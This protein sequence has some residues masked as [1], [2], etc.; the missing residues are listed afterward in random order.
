MS[1]MH[2]L[3]VSIVGVVGV[4]TMCAAAV[5]LTGCGDGRPSRAAVSGNVF[6]DGK[7]VACGTIML[8]PA[9]A[10]PSS[11]TIDRQGRFS[12]TCYQGQD[13]AVLGRHAL[14]VA[15]VEESDSKTIRWLAPKKYADYRTSGLA[16]DINGPTDSLRIDLKWDGG[17]PFI[18]KTDTRP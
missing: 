13:G 3:D 6:I 14:Q 12:L 18:E 17:A 5:M 4:C 11:G 9:K 16:V 1:R 15:V 2:A 7:P 10:R 8:I